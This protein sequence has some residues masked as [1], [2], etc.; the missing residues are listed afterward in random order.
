MCP[1]LP[2]LYLSIFDTDILPKMQADF[3]WTCTCF[4][5]AAVGFLW[6]LVTPKHAHAGSC[7]LGIVPV[8]NPKF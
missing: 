6:L 8:A 5:L 4:L 3:L 2:F 1:C 7:A